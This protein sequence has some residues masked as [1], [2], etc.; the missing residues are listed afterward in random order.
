MVNM[1]QAHKFAFDMDTQ[2]LKMGLLTAV[3]YTK[4]K[5]VVSELDFAKDVFVLDQQLHM[6]K[7]I[8]LR[9]RFGRPVTRNENNILFHNQI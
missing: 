9:N 1:N 4:K 2:H 7:H 6:K 3:Y 8:R 5:T